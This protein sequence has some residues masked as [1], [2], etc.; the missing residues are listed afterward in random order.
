[1]VVKL[2][3]CYDNPARNRSS[4]ITSSSIPHSLVGAGCISLDRLYRQIG[5]G[6]PIHYLE[7]RGESRRGRI[8]IQ[9]DSDFATW[10][11]LG[12]G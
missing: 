1:M 10:K 8:R 11:E 7:K 5:P 3:Y 12:N 2:L 6:I 9:R 4:R